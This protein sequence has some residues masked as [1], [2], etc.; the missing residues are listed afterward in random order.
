MRTVA[1]SAA[2][3]ILCAAVVQGSV[4][5]QVSPIE[6][7]L[8]HRE[9]TRP[10]IAS[11]GDALFAAWI[12]GRNGVNASVFGSRV[13]GDGELLDERGILIARLT[14]SNSEWY[15]TARVLP[16]GDGFVVIWND[17][18]RIIARRIDRTGTPEPATRIVFDS[19]GLA[20]NPF[21]AASRGD[22]ILI[23]SMFGEG[24]LAILDR[25][26]NDVRRIAW[27]EFGVIPWVVTVGTDGETF[28]AIATSM[29]AQYE[30]LHLSAAG[31]VI[32]RSSFANTS[33]AYSY[34]DTRLVWNGDSYLLLVRE[35]KLSLRVDRS[36]SP[37]GDLISMPWGSID[38]ESFF[39]AATGSDGS[40]VVVTQ[41]LTDAASR[42]TDIS[43]IRI[44]RGERSPEIHAVTQTSE[45]DRQPAI[46]AYRAGFVVLW[47]Q[48]KRPW[49]G[50]RGTRLAPGGKPE[51]VVQ[52]AAD[53]QTRSAVSQSG[54]TAAPG[55][56]FVLWHEGE[57][58]HDSRIMIRGIAEA[59]EAARPL[60]PSP[61]VP[62]RFPAVAVAGEEALVIWEEGPGPVRRLM[63]RRL[64]RAGHP[65]DNSAFQISTTSSTF[66]WPRLAAAWTGGYYLVAF[67]Q[68]ENLML[69]RVTREGTVVRPER[70][71]ATAK[72][73]E[74]HA[75]PTLSAAGDT[76]LLTWQHGIAQP[77]CVVL[78]TPIPTIARL[79]LS[80]S[81]LPLV[82]KPF[83]IFE[84]QLTSRLTAHLYPTAAWNGESLLVVWVAG[85][86]LY[87]SLLDRSGTVIEHPFPIAPARARP[88]SVLAANDGFIVAWEG[89]P[90]TGAQVQSNAVGVQS[91]PALYSE[92]PYSVIH[93]TYV[94]GRFTQTPFIVGS[95][96]PY[97]MTP[98]VFRHHDGIAFA[99]QTFAQRGA[100]DVARLHYVVLGE[101]PDADRRR[102]VR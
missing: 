60:S 34:G 91:Q 70:L 37:T 15:S 98:T 94:R 42:T 20:P 85:D 83:T 32:A 1:A 36:G 6:V 24:N 45:P 53:E 14:T 3:I 96:A 62:Q 71:I 40:V 86:V 19:P 79:R 39:D 78:C 4:E 92:W 25:N 95:R 11:N 47:N 51:A 68:N 54:L 64:T 28:V 16:L 74:W 49:S 97:Q 9:Q 7:S 89:L 101:A 21:D 81:G 29:R 55:T 77:P 38:Q 27:R 90:D 67:A 99:F 69:G 72:W 2:A 80:S 100:E 65:I 82:S 93:A 57:E 17:G 44:R 88:P 61:G 58:F 33:P 22:L 59:A 43:A 56:D 26:L 50:L 31:D 48:W 76:V 41:T 23:S 8:A 73:P 102:V 13:S 46:A 10:S 5:R 30:A 63:G 87:G 84:P 52:I 66:T 18:S 75:Y 35:E 12:D